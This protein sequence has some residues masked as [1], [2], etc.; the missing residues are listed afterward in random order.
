[1]YNQ[2]SH[3]FLSMKVIQAT[4]SAL[5]ESNKGKF[6]AIVIY[7]FLK[8]PRST[9]LEGVNCASHLPDVFV[10]LLYADVLL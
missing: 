3:V 9:N 2:Q 7:F 5:L 10:L 6:I 8:L 1:M 4:S